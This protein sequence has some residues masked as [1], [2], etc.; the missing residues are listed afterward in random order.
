MVLLLTF[1]F[2]VSFFLKKA[3]GI[4]STQGLLTLIWP[5]YTLA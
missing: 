5:S 3:S 4:L 2:E 1:N